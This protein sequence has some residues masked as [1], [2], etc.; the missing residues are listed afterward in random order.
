MSVSSRG[1]NIFSLNSQGLRSAEVSEESSSKKSG[2]S[3]LIRSVHKERRTRSRSKTVVGYEVSGGRHRHKKRHRSKGE[4]SSRRS[5][6]KSSYSPI[7][8][9]SVQAPQIEQQPSQPIEVR[10]RSSSYCEVVRNIAADIRRAKIKEISGENLLE[11]A[12]NSPRTPPH[13]ENGSPR[14]E[15]S[16]PRTPRERAAHEILK[17]S[18]S[19]QSRRSPPLGQSQKSTSRNASTVNVCGSFRIEK[20]FP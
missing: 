19:H 20:F 5:R 7:P 2:H 13:S 1:R 15:N 18:S 11:T 9:S 14:A 6:S 8:E 12:K 4:S 17:R 16:S 3:P 10:P